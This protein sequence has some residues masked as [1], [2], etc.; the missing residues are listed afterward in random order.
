M[1]RAH[2]PQTV[3]GVYVVVSVKI[4]KIQGW[5]GCAVFAAASGMALRAQTP[6]PVEAPPAPAAVTAP[7]V[8][9]AP[10]P[11]AA[12]ALAEPQGGMIHGTVVA[13]AAGKPGGIP[14]PGVAVTATNSLSGKK[15]STTT[16]VTGEYAMVIPRN[17]RYVV[18]VE[19]SAFAAQTVEVL[20]NKDSANGGKPDQK[21]DFG[22]QLASRVAAAEARQT[23]T[24]AN[25]ARG[26]QSLNLTTGGDADTE[27]AS[28][29]GAANDT[30]LPSLGG[31][32]ES[33]GARRTMRTP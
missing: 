20:L 4:L 13:G 6:A 29:G 25:P 10:N 30:S 18:K 11:A 14:L 24:A 28:L 9:A 26:L 32:A 3:G 1:A 8:V 15:Y 27:N 22:M 31:V 7:G 19:L 2:C 5:L 12:Q 16:D 33:S 21:A 17:G 23:A